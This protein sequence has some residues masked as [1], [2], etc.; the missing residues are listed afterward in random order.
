LFHRF[1]LTFNVLIQCWHKTL[2]FLERLEPHAG[3]ELLRQ[4]IV[5]LF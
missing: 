4:R 2:G 3:S 5:L 1:H